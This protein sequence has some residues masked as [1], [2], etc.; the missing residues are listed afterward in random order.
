MAFLKI[1]DGMAKGHRIQIDRDEVVIGRASENVVQ[2]DDPS[3]SGRHCSITRQGRR[4]ILRDLGS[5]NGTRLNGVRIDSYQLS[6]K[7]LISVGS[8]DVLFDGEDVDDHME[9]EIPPTIIRPAPPRSVAA[10]QQTE[11][12]PFAQRETSRGS[13]IALSICAGLLVLGALGW[14]LYN[15]LHSG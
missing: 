15:L 13:W 9:G 3:V 2:I 14:F 8:I 4:F 6:A 1:Q 10:A 7:D 5:T 11:A 12:I